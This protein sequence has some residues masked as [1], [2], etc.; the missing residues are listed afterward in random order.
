MRGGL[1]AA[2]LRGR[3][4]N[5]LF[6]YAAAMALQSDDR[7]T[8]VDSRWTPRAPG[9]YGALRV[10]LRDGAVR[11][12]GQVELVMLGQAPRLPRGGSRLERRRDALAERLPIIDRHVFREESPFTHDNR[13][14]DL[15]G[16]VLLSGYFQNERYFA[17]AAAKLR[18]A[19]RPASGTCRAWFAQLTREASGRPLVAL[20][21][22]DASDYASLGWVLPD[23]YYSAALASL[24]VTPG[25]CRF[26]VFG[27]S[28]ELNMLRARRLL[29][30]DCEMVSA[31]HLSILDQLNALSM[32]D[33]HIIPNSSFSWWGAWMADADRD[34]SA[35]VLAPQPWVDGDGGIVPARWRSITSTPVQAGCA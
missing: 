23:D 22:R 3:L 1:I 31:H 11:E 14:L 21:F 30:D 13:V 9:G 10:C 2:G 20:G 29:G 17:H 32:F 35:D 28:R 34:F 4:G 15:R 18:A 19:F 26:A 27:D 8:P 7:P 24:P 12:L 25:Q 6:Q 5:Q 33:T 16:P